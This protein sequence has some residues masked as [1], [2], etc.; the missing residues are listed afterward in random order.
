MIEGLIE[1][2]KW[3]ARGL[4][5]LETGKILKHR[6]GMRAPARRMIYLELFLAS[7][8]VRLTQLGEDKGVAAF[9]FNPTPNALKF[10]DPSG[11]GENVSLECKSIKYP[12]A[13]CL[14]FSGR[15]AFV[16]SVMP[17]SKKKKIEA[18]NKLL[19]WH[20]DPEVRNGE[21]TDIRKIRGEMCGILE[22]G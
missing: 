18:M 7:D 16:A 15:F 13:A 5:F 19:R 9:L 1:W 8:M 10:G 20:P 2:T 14:C 6:E 22:I 17:Y 3:F 12:Y 4:Y 21:I 11:S